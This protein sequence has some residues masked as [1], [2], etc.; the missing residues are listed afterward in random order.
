MTLSDSFEDDLCGAVLDDAERQVRDE[1]GPRL[2]N[3]ARENWGAY[4][5]RNGYDIGHIPGEAELSVERSD[6]AVEARIEWPELTALFE[7][8]VDPHTIRGDLHFYWEEI[9]QWVKTESVNWGSE[10]GG[11][12]EARAIRD[13]LEQ[14]GGRL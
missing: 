8:G 4:A 11:I 1:I 6:G 9:D 3:V 5:S 12:P 10:T 13:A 7:L 14:V 2:I